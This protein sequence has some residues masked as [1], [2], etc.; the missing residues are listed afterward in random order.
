MIEEVEKL[1]EANA[2]TEVLYPRWSSNTIM[3]KKNIGKWRACV[4]KC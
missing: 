2:I 4:E 3:V 1:K